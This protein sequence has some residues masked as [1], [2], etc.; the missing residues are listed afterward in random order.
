MTSRIERRVC[1]AAAVRGSLVALAVLGLGV[2]AGSGGGVDAGVVFDQVGG[3]IDGEAPMDLAGFVALSGDGNRVAIGAPGNDGA[4]DFAGHVRVFDWNSATTAWTQVGV[5]IDGEPGSPGFGSSYGGSVSMSAD[6]SRVAVGA[7]TVG[8]A[9]G[10]GPGRVGVYGWDGGAWAQIAGYIEGEA[11]GSFGRS[12]A[13]SANGHRVAGGAPVYPSVFGNV[14]GY[15][16]VFESNGTP[17]AWTPV[18]PSFV[19]EEFDSKGTSVSL[20]ADGNRFAVSSAAG[21][22]G[23]VQVY[24]WDSTASMWV[25]VGGDLDGVAG[26][27]FGWRIDLSDEGNRIAIAAVGDDNSGRFVRVYDWDNTTSTW[28]PVGTD[29]EAV[30]EGNRFGD[31]VAISGDGRRIAVGAPGAALPVGAEPTGEDPGHVYVYDWDVF[32]GQWTQIG[33][34]IAGEAAYDS[35]GRTVALTVDGDRVAVGADRND[36]NGSDSG[37]VRIYDIASAQPPTTIG[38][39]SDTIP[40]T[41]YHTGAMIA[42]GSVMTCCGILLLARSRL[43]RA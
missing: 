20:S 7:E 43:H 4:G 33:T 17:P 36:G 25:Q 6:G 31:S 16:A 22:G 37:H 14:S 34:G 12:V 23:R 11:E 30:T 19:G 21:E 41:G 2:A 28:A 5:D 38:P 26:D 35:F 27:S 1:R 9:D 32:T 13:L 29:I 18:G 42:I 15:A 3:D 40:A 8:A 10:S 24:D 39:V